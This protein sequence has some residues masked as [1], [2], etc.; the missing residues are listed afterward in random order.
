MRPNQ[1]IPEDKKRGILYRYRIA[2]RGWSVVKKE[3]GKYVNGVIDN[4]G[5]WVSHTPMK[6]T[7]LRDA[8]HWADWQM[9]KMG[10]K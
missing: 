1:A 4:K 2:P 9:N 10:V 3:G 7:N 8:L 6:H 5:E